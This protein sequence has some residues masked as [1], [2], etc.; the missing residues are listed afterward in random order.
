[1]TLNA[2]FLNVSSSFLR[3]CERLF[4]EDGLKILKII[5]GRSELMASEIKTIGKALQT[6]LKEVSG[7]LLKMRSIFGHLCASKLIIPADEF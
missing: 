2:Y 7:C 5:S 3:A 6:C 4:E 1:M